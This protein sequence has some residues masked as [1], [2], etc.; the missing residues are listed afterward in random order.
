MEV[1]GSII[2]FLKTKMFLAT[3]YDWFHLLFF[4]LSVAFG[5]FLVK[6]F[7]S[8]SSNQVRKILLIISLICIFLEVIKQITLC[9]SY[10]GEEILFSYKWYIFPFQF[11][12]TP[13][14]IGLLAGLF[15][16]GKIHNCC[17]AYLSSY[18]VFA[19]LSVMVWPSGVFTDIISL[20]IQTMICHG[21]MISI[22]IFLLCTKYVKTNFNTFLKAL[23]IFCIVF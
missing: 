23:P 22:G 3:P 9:F 14:Y 19:G 15:K 17:V 10:D 6:K 11:C 2:N 5:V 21:S 8:P 16:K 13:M 18:A 12:S 20:N 7:K 1:F 4:A